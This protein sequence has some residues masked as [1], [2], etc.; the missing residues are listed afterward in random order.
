MDEPK[1]AINLENHPM[2]MKLPDAPVTSSTIDS[3]FGEGQVEPK[4]RK[5]SV[6]TG[7]NEQGLDG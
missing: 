5:L 3:P 6:K 1:Q 2:E 7:R 4:A